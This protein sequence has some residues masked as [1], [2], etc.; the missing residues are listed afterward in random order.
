[1]PVAQSA[2]LL[3]PR[4]FDRQQLTAA[5]L[6]AGQDYVRERMRRHNRFMHGWGVVCGAVVIAGATPW[7]VT[8][9]EGYALT[10]DGDEVYVPSGADAFSIET[11]AKECL[12]IKA[13]CPDPGN[14]TPGPGAPGNPEPRG[15]VYLAL[16]AGEENTCPQ[17]ALPARCQPPGG[18][19]GFSRVAETYRLGVVCELPPSHQAEPSCRE[20]QQVICG[21]GLVSCPPQ[22]QPGDNGVTLA[23][24]TVTANGIV[25][26]DNVTP[27]R[28]LFSER[29]VQAW[30]ACQCQPPAPP[31]THFT[32]APFT[33]FSVFT[34]PPLVTQSPV[35][36]EPPVFSIFTQPPVVTGP[37]VFSIFTQPPVVSAPPA[38]SAFTRPPVLSLFTRPPVII[39]AEDAT[40]APG[41]SAEAFDLDRGRAER[42]ETVSGIGAARGRR[43]AEAGIATVYDLAT[44]A[45]EHIAE[46]LGVSVVRAAAL[47]AAARNRIKRG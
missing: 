30:L 46:V 39:R 10:P 38:V 8:V 17:P 16:Y 13:P 15:V 21:N 4:Y 19:Y 27:R 22:L 35:V 18:A 7:T 2:G 11:K 44:A 32:L 45:V 47:V 20:L 28:Q 33:T 42:V 6:T 36:T 34:Q 3:R 41:L 23:A 26:I 5:D 14:L 24:I 9:G 12:C 31:P 1:M 25:A 40:A 29:I 37:P 43:L